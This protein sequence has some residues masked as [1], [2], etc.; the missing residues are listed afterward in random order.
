[1]AC[2]TGLLNELRAWCRGLGT[3]EKKI[4]KLAIQV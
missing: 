3:C 2:F 1:L 4:A